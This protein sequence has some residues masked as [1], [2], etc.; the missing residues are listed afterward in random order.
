[1]EVA[2]ENQSDS[3]GVPGF[4][5]VSEEVAFGEGEFFSLKKLLAVGVWAVS[6][7][8]FE[9][10]IVLHPLIRRNNRGTRNN[11]DTCFINYVLLNL[12]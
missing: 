12:R 11:R 6:P 2:P 10:E 3:V 5:V 7:V 8:D 1:V 4:P 9:G